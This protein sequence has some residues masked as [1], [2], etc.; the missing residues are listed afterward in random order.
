VPHC[1]F[2]CWAD[3]EDGVRLHHPGVFHFRLWYR[4]TWV[5]VVIDDLL[6]ILD[7]NLVCAQSSCPNEWWPSLLE[8]AYAKYTG[9]FYVKNNILIISQIVKIAGFLCCFEKCLAG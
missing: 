6:P 7:G 4:G 2:Q 1:R 3:D 8:K 5:D 9:N